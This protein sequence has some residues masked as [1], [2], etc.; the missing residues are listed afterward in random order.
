ML[1]KWYIKKKIG[2]Y[3][4]R[5][6]E[7]FGDCE[8]HSVKSFDGTRIAYRTI[9]EGEPTIVHCPGVF[10]SYMFFHYMKDYFFPRHRLVF[11]DY[12]GHP[13]SEI[14]EDLESITLEN[15]ARDLKAVMDD[16]GVRKAV[17]TGHS[18][19]VMTILEFYRR[20]PRRVQGLIPINGPYR[21]GFEFAAETEKGQERLI[22]ALR[23]LSHN[24]WLMGWFRP[25]V[26]LP[27]NVP[28]AKKVE[29]NPTM[30]PSEEMTLYFDYVAKMDWHAGFQALSAMGVY[31]GSDILDTVKVPT[32]V[33]CG[34]S[35]TWAPRKIAEELHRRISGSEIVVIPGG[36]HA[37]PAENPQMI[38]YR[39]DLFL[40]EHFAKAAEPARRKAPKAKAKAKARAGKRAG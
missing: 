38:N 22:G 14:P 27:I 28:I 34:D 19:G 1:T 35:D 4:C 24:P 29:I 2:Q 13:E 21:H 9:G 18:M 26:I 12:R 20:F 30:C 15:C 8:E 11:W 7:L 39:I 17:L 16:A 37:T 31:D 33:V 40:K 23:F 6:E 25:I 3:D 32:L 5:M 36:S 10:T